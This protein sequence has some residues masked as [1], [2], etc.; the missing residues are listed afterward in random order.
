ML[1]SFYVDDGLLSA[2]SVEE[3]ILLQQ[4]LQ[5]LFDSGGFLLCK[6]KTSHPQVLVNVPVHL[7][8]CFPDQPI[9]DHENFAKALG[10]EWSAKLDCFRL[11]LSGCK[12]M[13]SLVVTKRV[14]ALNIAKIIYDVGLFSPS[15]IQ[16]KVLLQ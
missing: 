14:L 1:W 4:Q 6:W 8:D 12:F 15:I 5:E 10:I 3:A 16:V 13:E 7:L 11:S 2:N 9:L